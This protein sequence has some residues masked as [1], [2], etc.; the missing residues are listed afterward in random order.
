MRR[1]LVALALVTGS[2]GGAA[3]GDYL[4]IMKPGSW[5][6][7]TPEAYDAA[8]AEQRNGGGADLERLKAQLLD[9]KLCMYVDEEYVEKMMV[10]YA[11]ILERQGEKVKVS[12]TVEFR[13]RLEFLHR[14]IK[15]VTFGGWTDRSN[16][17]EKEIL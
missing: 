11:Q 16:L 12:F 7:S 17:V 8:V 3:G 6:C 10:P 2:A 14:Q 15:R 9:A 4:L 1:M 5:V 13:K